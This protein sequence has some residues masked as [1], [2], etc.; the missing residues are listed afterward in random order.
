MNKTNF[1]N[2]AD[3]FETP[4]WLFS[5]IK[6]KFNVQTDICCNSENYLIDDSPLHNLGFNA[7]ENSWENY[8]GPI[9][10]FPPFSKP[11]FRKFLTKAYKESKQG[12]EVVLLAPLKTLS[13]DYFQKIMPSHIFI[14]YPRIHFNIDGGHHNGY[15]DSI[16]IFYY[17]GKLEN[18]S[19]IIKFVNV[20]DKA[21]DSRYNFLRSK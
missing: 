5:L 10:C 17:D 12:V 8:A 11:H 14:L 1:K 21:D 13:V 20:L 3:E 4:P 7:L 6:N 18:N 9:Y 19:P 15:P 2:I 16:C